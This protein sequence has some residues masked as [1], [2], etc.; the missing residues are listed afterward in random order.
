MVNLSLGYLKL[1]FNSHYAWAFDLHVN[2]RLGIE[3]FNFLSVWHA[4][5]GRRS[6]DLD[7]FVQD[8]DSA[9]VQ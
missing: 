7:A 2:R 4:E 6:E 8:A 3:M 9:G 5:D 1:N